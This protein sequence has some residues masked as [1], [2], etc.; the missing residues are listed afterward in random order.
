MRETLKARDW[1]VCVTTYETCVREKTQLL[2]VEWEYIIVDEAHRLK[3]E[4]AIIS[5]VL[6]TFQCKNR[7]M[8]TGTP[9][10]NNLKELWALQYSNPRYEQ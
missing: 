10:Q 1:D 6:R 7:L 3:N 2:K 8:L 9:L 4:Q 5:Q